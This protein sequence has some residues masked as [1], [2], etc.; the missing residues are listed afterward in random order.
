MGQK[1]VC[2]I[3]SVMVTICVVCQ[4]LDMYGRAIDF[5]LLLKTRSVVLEIGRKLTALM[6]AHSS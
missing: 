6:G 4:A 3:I 2:E 1:T 5:Q